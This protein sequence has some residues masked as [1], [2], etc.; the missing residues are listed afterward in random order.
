M[1]GAAGRRRIDGQINGGTMVD[2]QRNQVIIGAMERNLP[3]VDWLLVTAIGEVG[4]S[5]AGGEMDISEAVGACATAT[6]ERS[7][8]E[9]PQR[10]ARCRR[11][12]HCPKRY[13]AGTT[14]GAAARG[15]F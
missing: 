6:A 5:R 10:P 8:N 1:P 15:C 3:M 7:P 9:M 11:G 2:L 4:G 12:R 14:N 13:G